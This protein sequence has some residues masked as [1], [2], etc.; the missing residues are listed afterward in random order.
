L[1]YCVRHRDDA[2]AI[3]MLDAAHADGRVELHVV[4]S[5][6][7]PRFNEAMLLDRFGP[8]GLAGAHVASCGP[9]ALTAEV[10]RAARSLG[11]SGVEVEAFDIR[12][13]FGPDLSREFD[14]LV[15]QLR[16]S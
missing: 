1:F 14:E 5:S 13:G 4:A 11:A 15:T 7:G 12:S 10:D 3:D 2:S 9:S 8:N 6:Q 16:R